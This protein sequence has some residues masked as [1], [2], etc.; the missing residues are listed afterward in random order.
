MKPKDKSLFANV[1]K[2]NTKPVA[3]A[4]GSEGEGAADPAATPP[5]EG[6]TPAAPAQTVQKTEGVQPPAAAAAAAAPAEQPPA[7]QPTTV[8]EKLASI[9]K[10]LKK[11]A[12]DNKVEIK[13]AVADEQFMMFMAMADALDWLTDTVKMISSDLK[14]FVDSGGK[15]GFMGEEVVKSLGGAEAAKMIVE[16][17]MTDEM[18]EKL[19]V[20]VQK[21]GAKMKTARLEKFRGLVS[22]LQELLKDLEGEA[23]APVATVEKSMKV[24][25]V[26]A[27]VTE[28]V[29]KAL[30]AQKTENEKVIKSLTDKIA[31]LEA[32]PVAPAGE[33]TDTT[34]EP[35]VTTNKS[36]QGKK[37]LWAGVI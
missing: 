4:E 29:T 3:K 30:A 6:A 19:L 27:V 31:K 35:V 37:S 12:D 20:V 2:T 5:A 1:L 13:K 14:S 11:N 7:A 34:E 24:E 36:N 28:E 26:K 25:D 32:A 33:G 22:G 9:F 10:S 15:T 17:G 18:F 23:P 16:E 21:K 8:V